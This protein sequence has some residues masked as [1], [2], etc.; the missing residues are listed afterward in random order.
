MMPINP[1]VV[2]DPTGRVGVLTGRLGMMGV[3]SFNAKR[4]ARAGLDVVETVPLVVLDFYL[5]PCE[6]ARD[7]RYLHRTAL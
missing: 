1:C 4:G 7:G 5:S 6:N 3:V 2:A